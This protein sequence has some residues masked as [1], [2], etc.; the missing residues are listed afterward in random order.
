[1]GSNEGGLQS[2]PVPIL[3]DGGTHE[4]PVPPAP[5]GVEGVRPMP[6]S[7]PRQATSLPWGPRQQ[8]AFSAFSIS[9][10][11]RSHSAHPEGGRIQG[12]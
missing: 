6:G 12:I 8:V 2:R 4:T 7:G 5:V 3:G 11:D 10:F 9:S 1:M